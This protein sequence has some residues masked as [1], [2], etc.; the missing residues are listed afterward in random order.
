[1]ESGHVTILAYKCVYQPESGT[2]FWCPEFLM[3]FHF[4]GM[5]AYRTHA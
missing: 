4:I 3:G 1:M 2:E 5:I